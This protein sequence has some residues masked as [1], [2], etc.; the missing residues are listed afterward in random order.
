V[1]GAPDWAGGLYDGKV[2]LP[3][4]HLSRIT[5]EFQA[6]LAHELT[7]ALIRAKAGTSCPR[8]LHE[9]LAQ[10][11]QGGDLG[12]AVASVVDASG[13]TSLADPARFYA[14]SLARVE[15]LIDRHGT[16][17]IMQ[18]LEAL[19][20]HGDYAAALDDALGLEPARFDHDFVAWLK[21]Q[22]R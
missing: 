9:G 19:K 10:H 6:L 16:T 20:T 13:E 22:K 3:V 11:Y 14:L 15:F 17:R 8:W 7:H 18:L 1:T 2:R 4:G 12:E 5:P 21:R